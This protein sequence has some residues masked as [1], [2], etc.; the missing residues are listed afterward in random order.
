MAD[1]ISQELENQ[2]VASTPDTTGTI[3]S[4]AAKYTLESDRLLGLLL[5]FDFGESHIV[6]CDPWKRKCGGVPRGSL[7]LF[8]VDQRAVDPEDRTFSNRLII[9]RIT[10]AVPTPV[11]GHVQQ[12]LFQVHKLQA[13]LD[14]LTNKDLQWGALKASIVGTYY[15]ER[16]QDCL[17]E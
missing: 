14:P 1:T 13:Q 6:T 5:K 12:T 11:E 8:R 9:A 7:V 17:R 4:M 2:L 3:A 10:D 16:G 15:D